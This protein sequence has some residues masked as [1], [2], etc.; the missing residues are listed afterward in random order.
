MPPSLTPIEVPTDRGDLCIPFLESH[1]F[2]ARTHPIRSRD[3]S[4]L[5]D[6]FG[7]YLRRRLGLR[8]PL[9]FS[10][11][12]SR[13][14]W[15]HEILE[16]MPGTPP[17]AWPS[18]LQSRLDARL[19]ELSDICDEC[20]L[21]A[22]LRAGILANERTTALS[23]LGW[24]TALAQWRLPSNPLLADGFLAELRKR[25]TIASEVR[26]AFRVPGV[27]TECLIEL[28][29]LSYD[30]KHNTL[31]IEDYKTTEGS[32][33]DRGHQCPVEHQN[34]LYLYGVVHNLPTLLDRFNLPADARLGGFRHLILQSPSISLNQK[35][36]PYSYSSHGKRTGV[37][38]TVHQTN[39]GW[40]AQIL[41]GSSQEFASEH[42]AVEWLHSQTGKAPERIYDGE[43]SLDLYA[44]RCIDYYNGA[45]DYA[46]K[47]GERQS[48][49]P[50]LISTTRVDEIL[51]PDTEMELL[52]TLKRIDY[53]ATLRPVP[54]FFPRFAEGMLNMSSHK[55]NAYAPFY[56]SPVRMWPQI[57][58]ENRLIPTFIDEDV[59]QLDAGDC[60]IGDPNV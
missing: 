32:V 10:K 4:C 35:D 34:R 6:P 20:G 37:S 57:A 42:Q 24:L 59:P 58:H 43:P 28:D 2:F 44:R 50:V 49:P 33:R 47:F 27:K 38:G 31:W 23:A 18:N 55:L 54:R 7:Y 26:I 3:K 1:G 52:D 17:S 14:S 56:T 5:S 16:F 19:K 9:R 51:N 46:D 45:G 41:G 8:D 36:R 60:F 40:G 30:E 21:H 22:E 39:G 48:D 11:A 29:R 53:F 25:H 13:G 12:L 15:A